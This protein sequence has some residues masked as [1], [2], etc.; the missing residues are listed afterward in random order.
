MFVPLFKIYFPI[1]ADIQYYLVLV[2]HVQ[3]GS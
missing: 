1:P 3:H 2:L